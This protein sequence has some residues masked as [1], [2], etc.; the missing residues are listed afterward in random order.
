MS[1]VK[2]IGDKNRQKS[3]DIHHSPGQKHLERGKSEMKTENIVIRPF[4]LTAML[5]LIPG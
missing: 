5:P 3:D 4:A 2:T 1:P